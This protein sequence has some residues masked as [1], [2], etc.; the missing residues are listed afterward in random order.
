MSSAIP[1]R[2]KPCSLLCPSTCVVWP[3]HSGGDWV[4]VRH[5]AVSQHVVRGG[6]ALG[7]CVPALAAALPA[8]SCFCPPTACQA[9]CLMPSYHTPQTLLPSHG[10]SGHSPIAGGAWGY[11][12]L[13]HFMQSSQQSRASLAGTNPALCLPQSCCCQTRGRESPSPWLGANEAPPQLG[14]H[15]RESSCCSAVAPYCYLHRR[16]L[17]FILALLLCCRF[18]S[19][20]LSLK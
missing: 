6:L 14:T 5:A 7:S 2:Q 13:L 8:P 11:L 10:K 18:S 19:D 3:F 12:G 9:P 15:M 17:S 1:V 20:V 16:R 4:P